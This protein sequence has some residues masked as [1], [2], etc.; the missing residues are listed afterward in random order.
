[1]ECITYIFAAIQPTTAKGTLTLLNTG[2][3]PTEITQ[4]WKPHSTQNA[5]AWLVFCIPLEFPQDLVA[6]RTGGR[7]PR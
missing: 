6:L 4:E 5:A 3:I 1:M 7:I 2:L